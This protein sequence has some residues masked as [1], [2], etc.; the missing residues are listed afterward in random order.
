MTGWDRAARPT[1]EVAHEA[2]I[3]T[4]PR[5]RG[6]IDAN[7]EKLR[8][9][10]AVLQAKAEWEQHGRR[11]DLLLPAGFQLE[12][13]RALL[14]DPGDLTIDD[15]EEFIALSSARE[16]SERKQKEAQEARVRRQR[17]KRRVV[18]IGGAVLLITAVPLYQFGSAIYARWMFDRSLEIVKSVDSPEAQAN[19]LRQAVEYQKLQSLELDLSSIQ[20]KGDKLNGLDL[21]GLT[22]RSLLLTRAT[23]ENVNFQNARL[24]SSSF[25]ESTI[26]GSNFENS[27]LRFARFDNSLIE[28]SNLSNTDLFRAV[29]SGAQ[30]C[31]L[32]F[33][34][35]FRDAS[36]FDVTFE[37]GEPP[38][39]EN[40]AWWLATGWNKHQ[41]KLL[42]KQSTIKNPNTKRRASNRS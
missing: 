20:L 39:F 40:S 1:V 2:L 13:A 30:L 17:T 18:T 28:S 14:A 26:S 23:L 34:D 27:F 24:P 19:A 31:R 7:R 8:A 25:I 3:R 4:W 10:A 35:A 15:I 36:F 11:E 16:E 21:R 22:G 41:R 38:N 42:T 9:R 33:S 5:L 12:R 37:D 6:W 32:D 29:F